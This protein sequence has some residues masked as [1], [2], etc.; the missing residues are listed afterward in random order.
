M[1]YYNNHRRIYPQRSSEKGRNKGGKRVA[2]AVK[3]L[4][5]EWNKLHKMC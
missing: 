5:K 4:E 2:Q 1:H 3:R